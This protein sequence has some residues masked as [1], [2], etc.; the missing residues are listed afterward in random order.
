MIDWDTLLR[1]SRLPGR[2]VCLE[3]E[4]L[5]YRIHDQA[6]TRKNIQNHVREQ[7]ESAMYEKM[8]PRPI[9]RILMHF[10]KKA[11]QAYGPADE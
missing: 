11:Y 7:E 8:W 9:P 4:L 2:F 10:Y 1:L 5:D 3:K 6:E